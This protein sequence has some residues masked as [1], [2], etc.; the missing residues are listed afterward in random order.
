MRIIS[1]KFIDEDTCLI[2]NPKLLDILRDAKFP[3]IK[4]VDYERDSS[5]FGFN[6]DHMVDAFRY[7][8]LSLDSCST[9]V[10]I[11][12]HWLEKIIDWIWYTH[13]EIKREMR[14][15]GV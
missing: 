6:S 1:N 14:K 11:K 8:V 15:L 5:K 12:K 13:L 10:T 4:I 7:S 2:V 9:Y 3:E